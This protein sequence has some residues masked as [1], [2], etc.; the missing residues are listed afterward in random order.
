MSTPIFDFG[1]S[2]MWPTEAFTVYPEPRY[3]LIVFALAGDSTTTSVLRKAFAAAL[4]EEPFAL[5]PLDLGVAFF[6][7]VL[8]LAMISPGRPRC[9]HSR[10]GSRETRAAD[11]NLPGFLVDESLQL[12]LGQPA[13][14]LLDAK[15]RS[16]GERVDLQGAS[17]VENLPDAQRRPFER[18]PG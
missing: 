12:Q 1:R 8:A 2:R 4:D 9:R 13:K 3:F 16:S 15:L 18:L 5:R 17:F 11:E 7:A 14:R 6:A 10:F